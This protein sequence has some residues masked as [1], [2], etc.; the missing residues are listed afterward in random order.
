MIY[1]EPTLFP[2]LSIAENVVMGYH[3]LA[4]LFNRWEQ[5]AFVE[6]GHAFPDPH[7]RFLDIAVEDVQWTF[8]GHPNADARTPGVQDITL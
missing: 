5:Q 8:L 1:Q 3:P 6:H 7:T 4:A 2:D